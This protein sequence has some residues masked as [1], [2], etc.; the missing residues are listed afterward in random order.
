MTFDPD[1]SIVRNPNDPWHREWGTG[2]VITSLAVI[3]IMAGILAYGATKA[4]DTPIRSS[5]MSQPNA[6]G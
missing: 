4:T 6:G 1:N 5:T 3:V 2:S